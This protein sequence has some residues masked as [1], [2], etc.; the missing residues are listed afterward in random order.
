LVRRERGSLYEP[1]SVTVMAGMP[2]TEAGK[3][4]KTLLRDLAA[5]ARY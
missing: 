1:E 4:D 3:P 2:L 5:R